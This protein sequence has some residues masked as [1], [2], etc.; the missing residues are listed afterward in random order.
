MLASIST[1]FMS[2]FRS[3][4]DRIEGRERDAARA[5]IS[6][7]KV[8]MVTLARA[9]S[10]ATQPISV[11]ASRSFI[12]QPDESSTACFGPGTLARPRIVARS[13]RSTGWMCD[14]ASWII[15]LVCISTSVGQS[16]ALPRHSRPMTSARTNMSWESMRIASQML[17]LYCW[18]GGAV[19][20]TPTT[21]V[22]ASATLA[23]SA[24]KSTLG[25]GAGKVRRPI[26][27]FAGMERT[28]F[29]AE[30]MMARASLERL[31]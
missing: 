21:R 19:E 17:M 11:D 23:W 6:A 3:S 12:A 24:V 15:V 8:W 9:A 13:E 26:R 16:G 18:K 2:R 25:P 30:P 7:V 1:L 31:A 28:H 22:S 27:S 10:A 20:P 5:H 14:C 29:C 4:I